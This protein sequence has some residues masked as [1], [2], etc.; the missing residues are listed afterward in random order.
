MGKIRLAI[1]V[2]PKIL[3]IFIHFKQFDYIEYKLVNMCW[4]NKDKIDTV[5]RCYLKWR[6]NHRHILLLDPKHNISSTYAVNG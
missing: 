1:V 4:N 5:G 6:F 3:L 2:Y